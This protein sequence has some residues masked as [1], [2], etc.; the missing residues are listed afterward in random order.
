MAI[1]LLIALILAALALVAWLLHDIR[2]RLGLIHGVAEGRLA[3]VV[4]ELRQAHERLASVVDQLRESHEVM[5][6]II[7]QLRESH[8]RLAQMGVALTGARMLA[9]ELE[10]TAMRERL[11]AQ[12]ESLQSVL[13]IIKS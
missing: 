12:T 2:S 11:E 5:A 10:Q 8:E 9:I 3:N 13:G 1:V 7:N 4:E 6:A